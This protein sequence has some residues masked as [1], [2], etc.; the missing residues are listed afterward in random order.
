MGSGV[1][2]WSGGAVR[3]DTEVYDVTASEVDFLK[4]C[5]RLDTQEGG[6]P[7]EMDAMEP[8]A[9]TRVEVELRLSL[10]RNGFAYAMEEMMG[11]ETRAHVALHPNFMNNSDYAAGYSTGSTVAEEALS[12]YSKILRGEQ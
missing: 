8:D 10:F 9:V 4:L 1:A 6:M 11:A 5:M 12:Q 3:R 7:T 2:P